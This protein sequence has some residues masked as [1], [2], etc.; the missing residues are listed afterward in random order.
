M[1]WTLMVSPLHLV[2]ADGPLV[3][4]DDG[5]EAVVVVSPGDDPRVLAEHWP[6]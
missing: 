1:S 3:V 5:L 4:F 2:A 6:W